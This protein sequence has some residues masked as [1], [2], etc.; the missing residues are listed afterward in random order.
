MP[1]PHLLRPLG[2]SGHSNM[3]TSYSRIA[4]RET[5][6]TGDHIICC[7]GKKN[8][9]WSQRK[10]GDKCCEWTAPS[11]YTALSL[12]KFRFRY[13]LYLFSTIF[14]QCLGVMNCGWCEYLR[15]PGLFDVVV[16]GVKMC[17][18]FIHDLTSCLTQKLKK[19]LLRGAPKKLE[20]RPSIKIN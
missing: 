12:L 6:R 2:Q 10:D 16:G 15:D 18:V 11:L 14:H 13:P 17:S 9:W 1:L 7:N 4:E 5:C 20:R 8:P 19:K 3:G